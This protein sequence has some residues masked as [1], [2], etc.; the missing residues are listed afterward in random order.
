MDFL[1][2]G[3]RMDIDPQF[4]AGQIAGRRPVH[5]VDSQ[6]EALPVAAVA[7]FLH[8]EALAV[9]GAGA[10]V[11]AIHA[12]AEPLEVRSDLAVDGGAHGAARRL[13]NSLTPTFR[14]GRDSSSGGVEPRAR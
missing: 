7:E 9:H 11:H 6:E 1:R 2:I 8:Q 5:E 14:M 3:L 13:V 12:G 4:Q 10:A